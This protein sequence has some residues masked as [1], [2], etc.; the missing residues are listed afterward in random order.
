MFKPMLPYA[1]FYSQ[2]FLYEINISPQSEE[3]TQE[4]IQEEQIG[5][6]VGVNG[7]NYLSALKKRM[8]PL[9]KDSHR[10]QIPTGSNDLPVFTY[11]D[12]KYHKNILSIKD[13]QIPPNYSKHFVISEYSFSIFHPPKELI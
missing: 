13:L 2:R 6:Y 5:A 7:R 1:V 12:F 9:T 11:D 4:V 8:A 3:E 10:P